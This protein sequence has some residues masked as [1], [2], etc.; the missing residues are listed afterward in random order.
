M[1]HFSVQKM[2]NSIQLTVG[3]KGFHLLRARE[4]LIVYFDYL[5]PQVFKPFGEVLITSKP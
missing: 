2:P 3:A 4:I 5:Y 1:K